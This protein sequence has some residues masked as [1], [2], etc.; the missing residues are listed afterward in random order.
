MTSFSFINNEILLGTSQVQEFTNI[1]IYTVPSG[2][3]ARVQMDSIHLY[4]KG[5]VKFEDVAFTIWSKPSNTFCKHIT[6]DYSFRGDGAHS[7]KTVSF[8]PNWTRPVANE[9][10]AAGSNYFSY[11]ANAQMQNWVLQNETFYVDKD[12]TSGYPD[13]QTTTNAGTRLWAPKQFFLSAGE[14]LKLNGETRTDLTS[15]EGLYFNTRLAIW[16]ED[17]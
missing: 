11:S 16:L 1:T 6:G 8:Y 14:V 10:S 13:A 12:V 2:K 7:V 17:V 3:V 9:F 15:S 4:A 5:D